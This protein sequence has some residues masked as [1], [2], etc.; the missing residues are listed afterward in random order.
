MSQKDKT[1]TRAGSAGVEDETKTDL[2]NL[3]L[4]LGPGNGSFM[5][6]VAGPKGMT[7]AALPPNESVS[8]GRSPK[9][10]LIVP[11]TAISR[12]HLT[13]RHQLLKDARRFLLRDLGSSNGTKLRGAEIQVREDVPFEPG[14][15]IEIGHTTVVLQRAA[16]VSGMQATEDYA[17]ETRQT[18]DIV[19]ENEAMQALYELAERTAESDATVLILG[20]TGVGKEVLARSIHEASKRKGGP[21]V[22]FNCAAFPHELLESELFGHEDGA[23]SGARAKKLG[24]FETAHGGTAFLDEI[25]EMPLAIQAKLLRVLDTRKLRRVGGTKTIDIDVRFVAA[26]NRNLQ[27]EVSR[28]RFREDLYYRLN[29]MSLFIPPLRERTDEIP[30]LVSK[31]AHDFWSR[32]RSKR[33]PHF[34]EDALEALTRYAW[35]GNIRELRNIVERALILAAG[36]SVRS[37]HLHLVPT[38]GPLESPSQQPSVALY[39]QS[40]FPGGGPPRF[41]PPLEVKKSSGATAKKVKGTTVTLRGDLGEL[42]KQRIIEALERCAGNQSRAAR[43]LGMPRRSFIRRLEQYNI[44][45]P[46]RQK[47]S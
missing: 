21:F 26:T 37:E 1:R 44:P 2:L 27:D 20:E 33:E 31:F 13:I 46:R 40:D 32:D 12:V 30:D 3:G 41:P 22:A 43:L 24:L 4:D 9:A 36:E 35:P 23:F 28:K 25:G 11:D 14:D 34:A 42:E 17:F 18:K 8:I 38:A 47:K 7:T 16:P 19:V 10:D 15:Q 5:I 29:V 6:F 45:R 39:P